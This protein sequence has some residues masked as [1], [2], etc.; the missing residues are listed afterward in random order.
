[1]TQED[2]QLVVNDPA[3]ATETAIQLLLGANLAG[4]TQ[5]EILRYYYDLCHHWGIDPLS[6]P[7]DLMELPGK[8]GAGK[9][10]LYANRNCTDQL[11]K[12]NKVSI[13]LSEPTFHGSFYIVRAVATMADGRR[14]E[15][16]AAIDTSGLRGEQ[17][18]NALMKCE[19]KAK[20]RV[21]LSIVGLSMQSEDE[22][23][24]IPGARR[25]DFELFLAKA[26]SEAKPKATQAAAL[27]EAASTEDASLGTAYPQEVE[28]GSCPVHDVA[29]REQRGS[30]GTFMSHKMDDGGY[31]NPGRA[32]KLYALSSLN[33]TQEEVNVHCN[34][35]FG[36]PSSKL[37]P[38]QC[39]EM[40]EFYKQQV[41]E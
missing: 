38:E 2:T 14:D 27:A 11:R 24:T 37:T 30:Q 40:F 5:E 35:K 1:V 21:T 23:D 25:V 28:L 39:T 10:Q 41:Q 19:T 29:W 32:I 7:L 22:V 3:L 16:T 6:R 26:D 36:V 12:R 9:L 15:S 18:A 20:R 4:L 31:C 13:Q 8:G 34:E 33:L 17:Y